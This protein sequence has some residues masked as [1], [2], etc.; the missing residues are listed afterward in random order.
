MSEALSA[1]WREFLTDDERRRVE[2]IEALLAATI[3]L[4]EERRVIELKARGR[5][6]AARLRRAA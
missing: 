1:D 2:S 3:P 6:R 4:R 5:S